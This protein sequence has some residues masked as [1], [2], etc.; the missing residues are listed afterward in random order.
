MLALAY[1]EKQS[2]GVKKLILNGATT[3]I[4]QNFPSTLNY[5]KAIISNGINNFV[6]I[7]AIHYY[8]NNFENVL[9][10]DGV[11]DFLNGLGKEIWITESGIRGYNKQLEYVETVFPFLRDKIDGINRIYYYQYASEENAD[12]A[13]GLRNLSEE[14]PVSDLYK[15]LSNS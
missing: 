2:L 10:D 8:G 5:N 4:A 12:Q 3:G 7:F 6:D 11:R 9:I 14:N 13:F 15:L 1:S